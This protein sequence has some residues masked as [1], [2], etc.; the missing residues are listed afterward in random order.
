M[1]EEQ[2]TKKQKT[3]IYDE[4]QDGEDEYGKKIQLDE[5]WKDKESE[6]YQKGVKYWDVRLNFD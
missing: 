4:F 5:L 3:D 2:K 1:E 6:W